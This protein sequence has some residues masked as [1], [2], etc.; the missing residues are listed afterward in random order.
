MAL[1]LGITSELLEKPVLWTPKDQGLAPYLEI[2][3]EGGVDQVDSLSGASWLDQSGN[4]NDATKAKGINLGPTLQEGHPGGFA[5]DGTDDYMDFTSRLRIDQGEPF[6]ICMAYTPTDIT[7]KALLSDANS[8]F[9][10]MMTSKKFRFK[11]NVGGGLSSTLQYDNVV[12]ANNVFTNLIFLRNSSN[13]LQLFIDGIGIEPNANTTNL[14][15][16]RGFDTFNL[17]TRNDSDKFFRG[18]IYEVFV[19][20]KA[21][22]S[23]QITNAA[24]YLKHKFN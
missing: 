13:Q 9:M 10:E 2:W 4:G 22:G 3:L 6:T 11:G 5:F 20:N 16:D 23:S 15:N 12:F 14:T 19:Y 8:E 7:T 18:V 1:G 21:I 24:S 17:A